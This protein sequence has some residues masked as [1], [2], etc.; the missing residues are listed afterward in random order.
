M[1]KPEQKLIF[2]FHYGNET[3]IIGH[4]IYMSWMPQNDLLG[5]QNT[6][7]FIS[8]CCINGQIEAL[9]HAVLTIGLPLFGDQPYNALRIKRTDFG[10][11]MNVVEF[12]HKNLHSAVQEIPT[13]LPYKENIQK[14]SDIFKSRPVPRGKRAT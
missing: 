10:I 7:I 14:A 8:H 3:K 1:F 13:D 11:I 2:V 9:Y 4:V 12:T 6:K 5:H